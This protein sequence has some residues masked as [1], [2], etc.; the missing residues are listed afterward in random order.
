MIDASVDA[1]CAQGKTYCNG[2]CTDT[3]KDPA[4]CDACG[5]YCKWHLVAGI[6][7]GAKAA[8]KAN[9]LADQSAAGVAYDDSI[10]DA[11]ERGRGFQLGQI[12]SLA[13][14][15]TLAATSAVLLILDSRKESAERRAW[16]TPV[17]TAR[18]ALLSG[19]LRF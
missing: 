10:R 16:I 3:V 15:G 9:W 5:V 4:N 19:S 6:V 14:G 2:V 12:I 17:I 13:A 7:L 18:G 1:E 8:D 11:E